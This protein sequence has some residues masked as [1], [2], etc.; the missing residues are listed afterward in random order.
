MHVNAPG[1]VITHGAFCTRRPNACAAHTPHTTSHGPRMKKERRRRK[2]SMIPDP[3]D[4]HGH[5]GL[6]KSQSNRNI[7]GTSSIPIIISD[8]VAVVS[9]E[10]R[11]TPLPLCSNPSTRTASSNVIFFVLAD[12]AFFSKLVAAFGAYRCEPWCRQSE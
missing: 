1:S 11:I 9:T 10:S 7:N 2:E 5:N 6:A 3:R 8:T 4:Q 12:L